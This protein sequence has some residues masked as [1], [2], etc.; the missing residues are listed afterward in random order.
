MK[1]TRLNLKIPEELYES[2]K[3]AAKRRNISL[4]SVV[5]MICSEWIEKETNASDDKDDV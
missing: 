3:Q 2:L 4:A 5:R 1:D